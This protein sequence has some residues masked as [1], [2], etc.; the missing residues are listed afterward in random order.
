LILDQNVFLSI[1]DRPNAL[2]LNVNEATV[3]LWQLKVWGILGTPLWNDVR[4][5][6]SLEQNRQ[7][8]LG[9]LISDLSFKSASITMLNADALAT[10]L[11][12]L[13]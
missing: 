4:D 3:F 12:S 1:L 2:R 8:S 9:N 6:V 7:S 11:S 5:L 13:A 10:R